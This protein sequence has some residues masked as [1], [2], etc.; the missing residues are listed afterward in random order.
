MMGYQDKTRDLPI[1]TWYSSI[2]SK[3]KIP[4]NPLPE[5]HRGSRQ[6]HS[7]SPPPHPAGPPLPVMKE[8]NLQFELPHT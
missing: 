4:E 2:F 1:K 6:F 8:L 7:L 5:L 3:E